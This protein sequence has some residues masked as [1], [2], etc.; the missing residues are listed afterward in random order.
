MRI[1][2]TLLILQFRKTSIEAVNYPRLEAP[3]FI[4]D[5]VD[6][7][8]YLLESYFAAS[9]I[10]SDQVKFDTVRSRFP[11]SRLRELRP[12]ADAAMQQQQGQRYNHLKTNLLALLQDSQQ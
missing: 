11:I 10:R 1:A 2:K 6:N 8:F 12:L 4:A 3:S 9:N 7:W 5:D